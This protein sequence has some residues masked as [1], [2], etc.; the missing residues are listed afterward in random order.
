MLQA[1]VAAAE[2]P[3][4]PLAG[5]GDD[6]NP[7][8]MADVALPREVLDRGRRAAKQALNAQ[9]EKLHKVLADA[10]IGSRRDMEEMIVA[11]RVSVNGQPAHTGQR[12]MP[13]DQ[14]RVNGKPLQ[15]R[16]AGGRPPRR[17]AVSQASLAR[18]SR[19]TIPASARRCFEKLPKVSGGRWVAVGTAAT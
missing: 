8:A 16:P 3:P 17:S 15:R 13:N 6:I 11:G 1:N 2:S 19:R 10:G 4:L 18:S 12:V 14:V 9:S 5:E 7:A